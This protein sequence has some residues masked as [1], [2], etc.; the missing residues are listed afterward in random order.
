VRRDGRA[1]ITAATAVVAA[2]AALAGCA[3]TAGQQVRV[4]AAT[5]VARPTTTSRA[6]DCA[7][8][9]PVEGLAAQLLMTMVTSP[10][11]A[12]ELVASGLV[13]GFGL[14]GN[15]SAD[16]AEEIAAAVADEEGGTVQRLRA[17]AGEVPAAADLAEGTPA[18]AATVL[19]EHAA[20]VQ[21]L[22]VG[23]VF[24][25]VAD[26]GTGAGLGTRTF[27]DDPATVADFV[28][29]IVEAQTAGG[30]VSVVKHWPGIGG[31]D[32]DPHEELTRLD[33]VAELRNVDLVPF[34]RAIAAGVPAVMVAHAEVPGLTAPDEPASLSAAAITGELRGRQGFAGLVITDELGM[35]AVLESTDQVDAAVRAVRA[36]ADVAL[37]SGTDVVPEAH[38]ALVAAIGSGELPRDQVVASVRRVLSSKGLDGGCLDAVATYSALARAAS[39]TTV[40]G[41]GTAASTTTTTTRGTG[42]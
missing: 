9:L 34:D 12:T 20:E 10:G 27:G 4:E 37:L 6:P 11:A 21:S 33:D 15:Q 16:V 29:A 1:R 42:R 41:Q 14:K 26:V 30:V 7:E 38:A 3:G 22:G 5:T 17:A 32:E 36:G 23:M 39:T 8:M 18:E 28:T 40:A 31:G 24:G 2:A 35:G 13:G 19:G 25:P